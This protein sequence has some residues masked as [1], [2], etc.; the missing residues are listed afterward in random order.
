ME[1]RQLEYFV[2][3]CRV[4]NF[5]RASENL[6]VAQP[7]I[8]KAIQRLEDE[9]GVRLV[10]RD[11][12]PIGL[13]KAGE[14][15][16]EGAQEVLGKLDALA[17]E[18]AATARTQRRV[19]SIG[20]SP[21]TGI[22]LD[23]ML[24]TAGSAQ[25]GVFFNIVRRS[26]VEIIALLLSKDLD[27]GWVIGE[28]LPDDLEFVPLETQ[29]ALL[30][31]RPDHPLCRRETITFADLHSEALSFQVSNRSSVLS[32]LVLKRCREAG[33]EPLQSADIPQFHPDIHMAVEWV[34]NGLGP[35][36]IPEHAAGDVM[37]LVV[38][39]VHPPLTFRTGL[40]FR[41][42]SGADRD[43]RRLIERIRAQYPA[44]AERSGRLHKSSP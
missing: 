11:R 36:F 34:R 3:L 35:S 16:Y 39:S 25:Q 15:L 42:G 28:D 26:S 4:R 7:S 32:R 19:V 17:R 6:N 24:T 43:T 37:D 30:L 12:K 8:T 1:L 40:A 31:L 41:K 13:T 23:R 18:V 10:E 44:F 22:L 21:F 9:L 33:F 2:E 38:A 27:L 20:I 29:E 14:M 5:T